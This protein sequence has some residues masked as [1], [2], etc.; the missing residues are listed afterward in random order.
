MKTSKYLILIL[1][2]L[3]LFACKK[4]RLKINVSD[5]K[6]ELSLQHYEK[7]MFE[8]EPDLVNDLLLSRYEEDASFIDLYTEE[9]IKIGPIH[10]DGFKQYLKDFLT[11]TVYTQVA[12]E[13]LNTFSNMETIETDL[14]KGFK[15]YRHYFPNKDIPNIYTYFS[16]FNESMVVAEDFIGI[17]LDKYLGSDCVFYEYLG[18][19]RFKAANMSPQKIV[20]DVFYAWAI[21]EFPYRDSVD[22]LLSNMIYQ[23]KLLYF[24]EAMSAHLPDSV[25]IGY[26]PDQL[27]WC[28]NH[29]AQM[30]TY[31]V[32][33]RLIYNT[34][35]LELRKY[36][37]D[38]PFT[39]T[40]GNDSPGRTGVWLGWQIVRS[41]MNNNK[42]VSLAELMEMHDAQ[43]L[44]N[45][46]KYYPD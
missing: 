45:Q 37:G 22:N 7:V 9:I 40:F 2:A 30:W 1:L 39:N 16:G 33:K 35:R 41:F 31:L 3:T 21:T 12:S 36:I 27:K 20:P 34:E 11:D 18:I 14:L 10:N 38:S 44:L 28:K 24:T 29:E 42:T 13:V 32:E 43:E 6:V 15:H 23:G 19:P 8:N 46:S 25:L 26:R 5:I 17:S 4:N